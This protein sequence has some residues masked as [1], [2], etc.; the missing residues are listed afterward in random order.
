MQ[1]YGVPTRLLD[2][3]LSPFVGLYF[4]LRNA[5]KKVPC[6][7]LWAMNLEAINSRFARVMARARI[8]ERV[9]TKEKHSARVGS[10]PD[11]AATD[12]DVMRSYALSIRKLTEDGIS[13]TGTLRGELNRRGCCAAF[14]PTSNPRL[15]NQQGVFLLNCAEKLLFADSLATLMNGAAGWCKTF[16]IPAGLLPTLERR[17]FQMNIHEQSLFPDTT[18]LAGFVRRKMEA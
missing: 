3:T 6:V 15:A 16:D 5:D 11:D 12:R 14:P 17:L 1:H 10:D 13:A 8:A 7:R 18:G 9:R 4:S 2:F